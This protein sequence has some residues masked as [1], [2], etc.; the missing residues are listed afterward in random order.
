MPD[1]LP[2]SPA[3][4]RRPDPFSLILGLTLVGCTFLAFW[5]L[6][7]WIAEETLARQQIRQAGFLLIAATA[8]VGWRER[9]TLHLVADLGNRTLALLAAAFSCLGLAALTGWP[10]LTVPGLAFGLAGCLTL[11]FG[12]SA[13][14]Y[15]QPLVWGVVTLIVFIFLFPVLDWPL[16][17]LAGVESARL[18]TW[19]GA[20]P[21]LGI[22]PV[23]GE[24]KLILK[25]GE[26]LF[27]VAT[28]CNGFGLITSGAL[29]ALLA[30]GICGRRPWALVGL[31]GGAL[32]IG[33]GVNLLRILA[34]SLLA[35][36]YP[37]HY[38]AMHEIVGTIAL[39]TGLGFVGALAWAPEDPPPPARPPLTPT[40]SPA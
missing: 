7:R 20:T 23:E 35:P 2:D 22:V 27:E 11:L 3:A 29:L 16:R 5:P 24:L 12:A 9:H 25:V 40:P 17:Q 8:L 19:L 26:H 15:F 13:L 14:R 39:W 38:W 4:P 34:I 30:G 31:I 37:D 36:Y 10:L 18:L 21:S 1:P 33:F 28:E 32:L 6:T